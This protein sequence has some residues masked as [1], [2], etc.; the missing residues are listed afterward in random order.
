MKNGYPN[1]TNTLHR[2][3]DGFFLLGKWGI[4][5]FMVYPLCLPYLMS[6]DV[7]GLRLKDY[8]LIEVALFTLVKV[9]FIFGLSGRVLVGSYI[10]LRKGE[11]N[12]DL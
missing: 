11:E 6:L 10:W 9:C 5:A 1:T 3:D 7:Y 12:I 4:I 2:L 8:P